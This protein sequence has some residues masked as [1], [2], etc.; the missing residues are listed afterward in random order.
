MSSLL[1]GLVGRNAGL[2]LVFEIDVDLTLGSLE[3]L[4]GSLDLL[5]KPAMLCLLSTSILSGDMRRPNL[6]LIL[7]LLDDLV[8]GDT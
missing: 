6:S 1:I 4:L 7:L 3:T 5:L 8:F 2:G